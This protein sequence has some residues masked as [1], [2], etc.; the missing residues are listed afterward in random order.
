MKKCSY[1][2]LACV[3]I[4]SLSA[5][6]QQTETA[7]SSLDEPN[8]SIASNEPSNQSLASFSYEE[9][10]AEYKDG[11]PGVNPNK[12]V[13]VDAYPIENQNAAVERAKNECTIEYNS[14]SEYYDKD[15][16]M[17]RVDFHTV[18]NN[19]DGTFAVLGGCQSVYMDSDGVTQL[20]VYDE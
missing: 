8:N 5:C 11:D 1:V 4:L 6:N 20:V 7:V 17:W 13:N 18:V 15:A 14:T 3:L 19:E 2:L 9:D 10:A 12:F 16:D